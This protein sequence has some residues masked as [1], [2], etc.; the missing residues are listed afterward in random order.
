MAKNVGPANAIVGE[1]ELPTNVPVT[2]VSEDVLIEE[3]KMARYSKTAEF[4]R[5][6]EFLRDRIKFFQNYLPNGD[7]TRFVK[8]DAAEI[9]QNWV[10]A[11]NIIHEF[12]NVLKAYE[13][14]REAVDRHEG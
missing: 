14:A 12:E 5:L 7:D 13:A 10:I 8:M 11:N 3:K 1:D 6:E 2:T 4:K 9:G